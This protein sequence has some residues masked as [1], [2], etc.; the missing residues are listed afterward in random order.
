MLPAVDRARSGCARSTGWHWQAGQASAG[1][2]DV[3]RSVTTTPR[4][5]PTRGG[6]G[7][8]VRIRSPSSG[9]CRRRP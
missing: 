8:A 6:A 7:E 3:T 9:L 5:F 1:T 2:P 4:Y